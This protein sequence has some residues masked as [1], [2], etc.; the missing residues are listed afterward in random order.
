MYKYTFLLNMYKEQRQQAILNLLESKSI[1]SQEVLRDNLYKIGFRA[2][3]ATLSRDLRELNVVK[4]TTDRGDYKYTIIDSWAGLPIL[5]C[6]A[7]GNLLVLRTEA[8]MAAAVAYRVDDLKLASVLGT[9]AGEDT[10][11]VV[12]AEGHDARK[13]RKQL[14][15][16][17]QVE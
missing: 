3:Q 4:T 11:L 8:G 7:S 17:I 12:I 6:E 10:I 15:T 9:V 16:R 5:G 2:T 13:V 14:W 1:S